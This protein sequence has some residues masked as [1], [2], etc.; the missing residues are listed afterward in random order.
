MEGYITVDFP[1]PPSSYQA[2]VAPGDYDT[3]Q[4]AIND[5]AQ[6]ILVGH[7]Y[8]STNEAYPVTMYA[9]GEEDWTPVVIS[10]V[11]PNST[12]IG[13][14]TQKADTLRIHGNGNHY[15]APIVVR[16]ASL[17]SHPEK[18]VIRIASLSGG[19]IDGCIIQDAGTPVSI[20]SAYID[21]Y[22]GGSFDWAI[23]NIDIWG[24]SNGIRID[25]GSAG[26]GVLMDNVD[27]TACDGPGV[28]AEGVASV[29]YRNGT[30][31]LNYGRG[32]ELRDTTSFTVDASY[33]EGNDRGN[34]DGVPIEVYGRRA[35]STTIRDS[36][37]HGI[38]PRGA[39][40]AHDLVQR[41]INFHDSEGVSVRDCDVRRYGDAFAY[42]FSDDPVILDNVRCEDDTKLSGTPDSTVSPKY[43]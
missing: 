36:Y 34:E 5:G 26:H 38:N 22:I 32:F 27:I 17:T 20:E 18:T 33:V 21:G 35:H 39:T 3:I 15:G 4:S 9:N 23:Q 28:Y 40:H 37:F 43:V 24:C 19:L 31:Q 29:T 42:N 16:N 8:D 25:G 1:D 30:N 13:D 11:G 7:E 10:G 6:S 41:G 2:S 14:P 12:V